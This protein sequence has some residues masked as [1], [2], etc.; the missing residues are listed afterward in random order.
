ML[1]YE[2]KLKNG[3]VRDDFKVFSAVWKSELDV[4]ADSLSLNC[5]YDG[6]IFNQGDRLSAYDG[7]TLILDEQ[8]TAARA[9]RIRQ[10]M[11]LIFGSDR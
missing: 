2:I 5:A 8:A 9:D 4:P 11:D 6:E 1:R 7:D 10:K 3:E